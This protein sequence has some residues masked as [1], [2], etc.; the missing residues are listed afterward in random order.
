MATQALIVATAVGGI[1]EIV[2]HQRD[3]LLTA[4]NPVAL[5]ETLRNVLSKPNLVRDLGIA[6]GIT[7]TDRFQRSQRVQQAIDTIAGF[8]L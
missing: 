2:T 3:G 8:A 4:P 1:P 6:A 7:V 5:A